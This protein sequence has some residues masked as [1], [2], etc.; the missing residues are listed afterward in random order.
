MINVKKTMVLSKI[1]NFFRKTRI[2][3]RLL[4]AMLVLAILPSCFIT[5]YSYMSYT[6]EIQQ[7]TE[8]YLSLL[9]KN[10]T[11][12]VQEH[13]ELCQQIARSVYSDI[14]LMELVQQN[15]EPLLD[16]ESAEYLHN[17]QMIEQRLYEA[18]LSN[19]YIKNFQL[20]TFN[21]QYQMH[22]RN[23]EPRGA[24]IKDIE[25]FRKSEFFMQA[26][27]NA[28]YPVWF[29]TTQNIDLIHKDINSSSGLGGT[30]SMTV[31]VNAPYSNTPMGILMLNVDLGFFTR[32]L[33][34][35]SFYGTGNTVFLTNNDVLSVLN[36][37]VNA[38]I[39]EYQSEMKE[40]FHQHTKGELT[41]Q[42]NNRTLFICFQKVQNMDLYIA[43]VVDLD[44]LLEPAYQ[45]R[46]HSFVIVL[47]LVFCCIL[48][49]YLT[50]LSIGQPLKTLLKSIQRFE[51]NW[52]AKRCDVSG[53]D[54]LTYISQHFNQMADSTQKMADELVQS[55][56]KQHTLELS[57]LKAELNALQ[58]QIKPHFLYN[59]LD[60]IRWETIHVG[61][62]ESTASYMIDRFSALLRKSI[63]KNENKV[64]ISEELEHI[65][66]Y[67]DVINFSRRNKIELINSIDFDS[68]Q[69]SIPKLS[70]QPI[71]ENAVKHAFDSHS[72]H[73]AIHLRGWLI[74]QN[75]ILITVTDNGYGMK[76]CEIESLQNN[77]KHKK[78]HLDGIG[79]NNV[80]LR[81]KL[82]Y[83]EEY[84]LDVE[85]VL[86]LGTEI[87]LRIPADAF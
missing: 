13:F 55:N 34:N 25:N 31:L 79:L 33:K 27:E 48:I 71:V 47:I 11:L 75:L 84:G 62:G 82:V 28:G 23:G 65:Q 86:D 20:I 83:G 12:Q 41:Q 58:M 80:N 24:M 30:L 46:H 53:K 35:Y 49:A 22:N 67:I 45:L 17:K 64:R 3:P 85:S 4:C 8:Q 51:K 38:P 87:S 15:E 16:I 54:E 9:V 73:P 44:T 19:R 57:H 26:I 68:S 39:F 78:L 59:T 2:F 50:A 60:L 77:L 76:P 37:N 81:I 7:N 61:K 6:K 18:S 70:L 63:K 66:A 14:H 5:W 43:H 42:V 10:I 21:H 69:Y 52:D 36:P 1:I 72:N 56:L 32:T 74:A 40:F 29:D